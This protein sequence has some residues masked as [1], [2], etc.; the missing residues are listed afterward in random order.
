MLYSIINFCR[1]EDGASAIEYGLI[2]GVIS[3]GLIGG[4]SAISSNI[5]AVFQFIADTFANF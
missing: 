5:N 3:V 2:V 4:A 1:N